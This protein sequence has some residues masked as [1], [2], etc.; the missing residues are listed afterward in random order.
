MCPMDEQLTQAHEQPARIDLPDGES[1]GGTE[2]SLEALCSSG[3]RGGAVVAAPHPLYGG[4]LDFPVVVEVARAC[5]RVGLSSLRFNWRG[6][7]ASSGVPSGDEASADAD[8]DA[9]VAFSQVRSPGPVVGC[10]YSFGAAAAVRAA[11]RCSQLHRLV[12]VAPPMPLLDRA[13]L[14]AF[15]HPVLIVVGDGDAYAP[16][17]EVQSLATEVKR[18]ELVTLENTDHFFMT[19]GLD[20][21]GPRVEEWLARSLDPDPARG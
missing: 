13:A 18:A 9:A 16:L 5:Q 7:G 10:G 14:R 1:S 6:V 4:S 15:E 3:P 2:I 8:Y 21:L 20:D 19:G 17:A 11:E 12:L